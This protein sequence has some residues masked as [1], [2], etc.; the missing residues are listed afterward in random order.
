MLNMSSE[1][2]QGSNYLRSSK[3][4]APLRGLGQVKVSTENHSESEVESTMGQVKKPRKGYELAD[5]SAAVEYRY[6]QSYTRKLMSQDGEPEYEQYEV[7]SDTQ[8]LK[9]YG[10]GVYLYL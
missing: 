9:P 4:L 2:L 3:K 5:F 1:N 6:S 7:C 8:E 10:L